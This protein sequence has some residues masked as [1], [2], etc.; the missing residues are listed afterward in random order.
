MVRIGVIEE[1]V[2]CHNRNH[3]S[4]EDRYKMVANASTRPPYVATSSALPGVPG[5]RR[6]ARQIE[7]LQFCRRLRSVA[8]ACPLE[9]RPGY[10][11]WA[12]PALVLAVTVAG[13][14]RIVE[15]AA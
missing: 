12:K 9:P 3:S 7:W 8:A 6:L 2:F 5:Q 11:S 13:A 10:E 14:L 15:L 1:H 4:G